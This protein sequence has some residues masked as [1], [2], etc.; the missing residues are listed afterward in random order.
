MS[1]GIGRPVI[2]SS[3]TV[4]NTAIDQTSNP[5]GAPVL[6]V[7]DEPVLR[8]MVTRWLAADGYVCAEAESAEAAWRHLQNNE[9]H[10]VTLDVN[11]P[12]M[13]SKQLL[14]RIKERLPETEVLMLTARAE[15]VSAIEFLTRGAAAYLIKPVNRGELIFQVEKALEH[16]QLKIGQR[17]Y[18]QNLEERVRE[19]T[20]QIRRAHEETIHRLVNASAYRD[21][22]TGAH[23]KRVGLFGGALAQAA[24]WPP[25]QVE[26][27]RM[28][29]CM[30]DVGKIGIPDAILLKPGRLTRDEFEL[31]KT[32]TAIGARMLADAESPM[33]RIAHD[34]ALNHHERWDGTGYPRGLADSAI[35]E[36]ARITSIVDVYDALTHD[37]VYR[38]AFPET[39]AL[40]MIENG[41]GTQFDPSLL[42]LFFSTLPHLRQIALLNPD[43]SKPDTCELLPILDVRA[44]SPPQADP[45]PA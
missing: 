14:D 12:G 10:L 16:R 35:P 5:A 24:G 22:E 33:L 21:E 32:H 19:Q 42:D 38:P 40:D 15:A 41:R 43:E 26:H 36:S 9:V 37:R 23:I 20:L 3:K 44:E 25:D 18:T 29:A 7:D 11:M 4:L 28:A 34:I 45:L 30:H 8:Y 17:E 39:K 2:T 27:M 1:I 31:M 13:P 6:V